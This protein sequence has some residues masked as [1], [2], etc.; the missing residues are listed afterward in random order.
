[1][2][3]AEEIEKKRQLALQKKKEKEK[4]NTS[5]SN[6][7]S[8]VTPKNVLNNHGNKNASHNSGTQS[9]QKYSNNFSNQ[10]AKSSFNNYQSNGN[11][12]NKSDSSLKKLGSQNRFN[13]MQKSTQ[14]FY[15]SQSSQP[16][17][18]VIC[19]MIS[20]D[21]F[22]ADITQF[23]TQLIDL[24]KTIPTRIYGNSKKSF[25]SF[26]LCFLNSSN[27]LIININIFH[28]VVYYID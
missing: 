16:V 10:N 28:K 3:S 12:K 19:S 23:N 27:F 18:E 17:C 21:R 15:G 25:Y 22:S 8:S 5:F 9:F 14:K 1:M 26:I 20:N 6:A 24:F 7:S 11:F 2:Y 13:P 4:L